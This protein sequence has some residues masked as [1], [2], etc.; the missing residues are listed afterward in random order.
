MR[1][2]PLPV[3]RLMLAYALMMA[4][5]SL[6]VLIA[7]II[8]TQFAPSPGL[9]T[10][11]IALAVVGLASSTLPTGRL[12][13]RFGRRRV[14]VAYGLLAVSAA[15]LAAFSLVHASFGGFC[16]AATL[17]GWATAAGH[18]YRFAAL[19]LVPAEQAPKATSILLLG[20]I[21]AA[22]VG[23]E[24]AVRGRSLLATEYAGS[25]LLL[26]VSY[27]AGIVL[28]SLYRDPGLRDGGKLRGGRPL[29]VI[30][31]SP[32]V[33]LAIAASA[34]GYGVM[35]LVMTAG[36][37]SMHEYSHHSLEATK[38]VLQSHIA[39]MYVPSLVYPW[40]FSR[41]H[42][43]GMLWGGLA[44]FAACLTVASIDTTVLHY[45]LTMV[46]LGVGWNFLFLSGT[47]LLP[48]GY[49]PEERFKIQSLNDFLVFSVQAAASLSSGWILF[50]FGW[51]GMID[52]AVPL[53]LAFAALLGLGG[54]LRDRSLAR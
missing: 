23:P 6:M 51:Q 8:G 25:F 14:F 42:F 39:G 7:G 12:L 10:L 17:M 3:W 28:V 24:I 22:F 33:V 54:G 40:L 21:L 53:L 44:A 16:L 18:Q 19:E 11:P 13:D 1:N 49:R 32:V 15:L 45:W 26:A 43:R 31:R 37:V 36:P 34:L 35:S 41:L 50:H 4:G 5:S 9:A 29:A 46:L 2:M 52:A 47:N 20:G 30:V 27:G 48:H 38:V